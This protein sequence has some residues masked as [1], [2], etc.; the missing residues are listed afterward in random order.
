MQKIQEDHKK[1]DRRGSQFTENSSESSNTF[2]TSSAPPNI[3]PSCLFCSW[4][5]D[6]IIRPFANSSGSSKFLPTITKPHEQSQGPV[7]KT[8]SKSSDVTRRFSYV[9]LST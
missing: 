7:S 2:R 9:T 1:S 6:E 4:E 5:D 8:N 3:D